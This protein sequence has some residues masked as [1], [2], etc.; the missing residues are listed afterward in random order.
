MK[1]ILLFLPVLLNAQNFPQKLSCVS[2]IDSEINQQEV[3]LNEYAMAQ[4]SFSKGDWLYSAEV[5]ENRLNFLTIKNTKSNSKASV[6]SV[7]YS[8]RHLHVRH[9]VASTYATVDCELKF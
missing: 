8:I 9:D 2:V 3:R 5:I 1:V 4:M 7:D 6:H